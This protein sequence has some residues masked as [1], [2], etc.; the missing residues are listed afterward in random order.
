[1]Q[2]VSEWA[3]AYKWASMRAM[4]AALSLQG[5][6]YAIPED[7]RSGLPPQI[8]AIATVALLVL[9]II[10]R[11]TTK[12][13]KDGNLE[14]NTDGAE[15]PMDHHIGDNCEHLDNCP[16]RGGGVGE[17]QVDGSPCS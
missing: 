8:L 2:L 1:M 6:W 10:G 9:G 15:K 4:T 13:N 7:M 17:S 14:R 11:I 16:P 12:G 3:K 5:A